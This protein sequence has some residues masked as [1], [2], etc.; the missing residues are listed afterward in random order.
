MKRYIITAQCD[1]HNARFHHHGEKVLK[2]DG[3]T[4]VKWVLIDEDMT[5]EEAAERLWKLALSEYFS[6]SNLVYETADSVESLVKDI[7]SEE[8]RPED[9]VHKMFDWFKGDGIYYSQNDNPVAMMLKGDKSYS[10]DTMVYRVEE[11]EEEL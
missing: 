9:E 10:Y 5:E 8:D 4:P 3:A 2:R 6:S 11:K 7:A 1:P